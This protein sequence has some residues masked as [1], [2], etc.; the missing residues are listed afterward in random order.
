MKYAYVILLFL[1]K[2]HAF[3]SERL[4]FEVLQNQYYNSSGK[5]GDNIPLDLRMEHLIR[6]ETFNIQHIRDCCTADP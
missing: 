3:L 1:A 4:A 6:F 5:A 2:V